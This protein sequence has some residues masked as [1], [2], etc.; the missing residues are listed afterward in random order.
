MPSINLRIAPSHLKFTST[1]LQIST[2]F[3]ALENPTPTSR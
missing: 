3:R 2:D 1:V